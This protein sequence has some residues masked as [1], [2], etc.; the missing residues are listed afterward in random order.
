M[1]KVGKVTLRQPTSTT[2][3]SPNF[4]PKKP[5]ISLDNLQDVDTQNVEEG[6]TLVY[7]SQT[8]KYEMRSIT[9]ADV[10]ISNISGGKF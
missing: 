10:D 6:Y 4:E 7:N 3:V 5:V 9:D 2:V 1:I 8:Q